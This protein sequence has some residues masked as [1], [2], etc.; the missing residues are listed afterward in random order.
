MAAFF[1]NID[2]KSIAGL[3]GIVVA[4]GGV[5]YWARCRSEKEATHDDEDENP[6]AASP[7]IA[8]EI[9]N[10]LTE[11]E[12]TAVEAE[13]PPV[14]SPVEEIVN[15]NG[16]AECEATDDLETENLIV[17]SQVDTHNELAECEETADFEVENL[18]VVSAEPEESPEERLKRKLSEY[19]NKKEVEK[20]QVE[21]ERVDCRTRAILYKLR[22]MDHFPLHV[23]ACISSDD[24]NRVYKASGEEYFEFA[25]KV[26]SDDKAAKREFKK[27]DQNEKFGLGG[28]SPV[29]Y[30]G[31]ILIT[32][33][34]DDY[35]KPASNDE[36]QDQGLNFC[37]KD[38]KGRKDE[39]KAKK[40]GFKEAKRNRLATSY[41]NEDHNSGISQ[42]KRISKRLYSK[43]KCAEE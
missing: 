29:L 6:P 43:D 5:W 30:R 42:R 15:E 13:N 4:C 9:D 39:W 26:H 37:R 35:Y 21:D 2:L 34:M 19:L 41:L 22:T 31:N 32:K 16:L 8:N 33:W 11:C 18:P 7:V 17:A 28:P 38:F 10:G 14:A 3:A 20:E 40:K 12:E 36:E 1:K 23:E 27:L 25:I 24:F